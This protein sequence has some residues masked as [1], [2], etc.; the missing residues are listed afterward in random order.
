M[1]I[2]SGHAGL[3]EFEL[4]LGGTELELG[5]IG[6]CPTGVA[7]SLRSTADKPQIHYESMCAAVATPRVNDLR[8]LC[9]QNSHA[10]HTRPERAQLRQ[11]QPNCP[12]AV[13]APGLPGMRLVLK[14]AQVLEQ[15]SIAT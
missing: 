3:K 10:V 5:M 1:S 13:L 9:T 12:R 11:I 7:T 2:N 6:A 14:A 15:T 8:C 4:A